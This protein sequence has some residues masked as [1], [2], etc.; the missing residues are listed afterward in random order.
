LLFCRARS[1]TGGLAAV[2][3]AVEQPEREGG[4]ERYDEQTE[5]RPEPA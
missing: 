2:I 4:H 1:L 5:Q 3:V